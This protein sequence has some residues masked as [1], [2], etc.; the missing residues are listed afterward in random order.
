MKKWI[1]LIGLLTYS[2]VGWTEDDNTRIMKCVTESPPLGKVLLGIFKFEPF[3]LT[4]SGKLLTK[5]ERGVWKDMCKQEYDRLG[6]DVVGYT[7][8]EKYKMSEY[9]YDFRP[10]YFNPRYFIRVLIDDSVFSRVL[11]IVFTVEPSS[12]K[13][14]NISS[15]CSSQGRFLR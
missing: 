7:V 11:L 2:S 10:T 8:I 13:L 6:C 14:I 5:R 1:L 3:E 9:V 4:Y 12:Y 15:S